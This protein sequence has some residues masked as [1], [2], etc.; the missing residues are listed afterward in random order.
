M[1]K[2]FVC[3]LMLTGDIQTPEYVYV[4]KKFP[5]FRVYIFNLDQEVILAEI[6]GTSMKMGGGYT[7][8]NQNN[9]KGMDGDII[10]ASEDQQAYLQKKGNNWYFKD[11]N[12]RCFKLKKQKYDQ[13]T[14]RIRF[15]IFRMYFYEKYGGNSEVKLPRAD[16]EKFK[17]QPLEYLKNQY[18]KDKL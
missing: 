7:R 18:L 1:I 3:L 6:G 16:F 14:D 15:G 10:A 9:I 13:E 17:K 11:K 4:G 2:L 5:G 12:G 8:L